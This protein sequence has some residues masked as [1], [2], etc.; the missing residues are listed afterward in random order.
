MIVP[1]FL[2]LIVQWGWTDNKWNSQ[3][4][5]VVPAVGKATGG[6]RK[7]VGMQF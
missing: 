2:K 6:C 7:G 5:D 1:V 3:H 4:K